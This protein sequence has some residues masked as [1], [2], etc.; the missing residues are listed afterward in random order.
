MLLEHDDPEFGEYVG[1]GIVPE[2]LGDARRGALV[3]DLGGGQ[4]QRARST[5]ACSASPTTSSAELKEEGVL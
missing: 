4:P 3:G 5:A 2:V 1:P